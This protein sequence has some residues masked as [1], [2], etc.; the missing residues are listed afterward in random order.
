MTRGGVGVGGRYK[1]EG[2]HV[3]IH[4]WFTLLYSTSQYALVKRLY[5]NKKFLKITLPL[6]W[7]PSNVC[8]HKCYEPSQNQRG[9][10]LLPEEKSWPQGNQE[11][12]DSL[13]GLRVSSPLYLF[14]GEFPFGI[15]LL[16]FPLNREIWHRQYMRYFT[17]DTHSNLGKKR[18]TLLPFPVFQHQITFSVELLENLQWYH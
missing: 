3:Y 7:P 9:R 6:K 13:C 14:A 8:S 17:L 4:S 18:P 5:P 2:L 10:G 16:A 11:E 12:D 1:R 15:C